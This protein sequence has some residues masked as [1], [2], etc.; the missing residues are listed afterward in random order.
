LN[1]VN[2]ES[3]SLN[4]EGHEEGNKQPATAGLRRATEN[5]EAKALN[6][7]GHEGF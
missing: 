2:E 5:S 4:H 7:E 3:K 6:H 1:Q